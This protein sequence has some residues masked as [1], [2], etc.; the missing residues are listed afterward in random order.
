MTVD[1]ILKSRLDG[2]SLKKLL[3]LDNANLNKLIADAILRFQPA[4]VFVSTGSA[5]DLYHVRAQAIRRG[6]EKP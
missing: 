3:A 1:N 2:G 4:S 5:E 6:E